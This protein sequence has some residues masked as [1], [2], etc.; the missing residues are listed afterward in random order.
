MRSIYSLPKLLL[1]SC[2][3]L[4]VSCSKD[5][6]KLVV[7]DTLQ[8]TWKLS[9]SYADIGNGQGKWMPV[10]EH[11]AS[12]YL[13]TFKD[14]GVLEG[15]AYSDYSTYSVKDSV[16]LTFFKKDKTEQN[17]RFKISNGELTMSPA[18]PIMCIEGCGSKFVKTK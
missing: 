13:V 10:S 15:N 1:V 18:G 14:N 11:S 3:F 7:D 5:N 2:L 16:T 8:G 9:A 4:M 12:L 6:A 17:Y